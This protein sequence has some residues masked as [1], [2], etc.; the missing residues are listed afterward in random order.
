[1]TGKKKINETGFTLIEIIVTVVIVAILGAMIITFLSDSFIKSSDPVKRLKASFNLNKIMANITADYNQF[2]RWQSLRIYSVGDKVLPISMNGRYYTCVSQGISGA[3]EPNWS[4]AGN[5]TDGTAKWDV[6]P[7]M[8]ISTRAGMWKGATNYAIGDIVIPT[9]PNGHFYRCKMTGISAATEPIWPKTGGST[10]NDGGIQWVRFIQYLKEGVGTP[11]LNRKNNSYGQC[12]GVNCVPY[13][14]TA[15]KFIKFTSNAE[16][17]SNIG[18]DPENIL[19]VT[20]KNDEG[21][22]LTALFMVKES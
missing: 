21:A 6:R 20:I 13:Y 10:I 4:D 11:D 14:V 5:V 22:T 2:P 3:S 15:N 8:W 17:D 7:W 18:V 16:Q 12:P 19:K 9:N 1:M